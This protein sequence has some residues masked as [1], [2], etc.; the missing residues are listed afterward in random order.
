MSNNRWTTIICNLMHKAR[1]R[2][3]AKYNYIID[4]DK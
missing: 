2:G 4:L 3:I 1:K